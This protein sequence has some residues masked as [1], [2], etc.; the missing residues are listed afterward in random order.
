MGH[1]WLKWKSRFLTCPCHKIYREEAFGLKKFQ[2]NFK[3]YD[4][5]E[6]ARFQAIWYFVNNCLIKIPI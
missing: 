2:L 6:C 4:F 3:T 1:N 5:C